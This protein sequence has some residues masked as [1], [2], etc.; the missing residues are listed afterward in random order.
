ML[1]YG[2]SG[3]GK[4]TRIACVLREL[5]G[6][7]V[8]KVRGALVIRPQGQEGLIVVFAWTNLRRPSA[9]VYV[10]R[11]CPLQLKIDQRVFMTPSRRNLD[12]NIVQSNYHLEITP[13]YASRLLILLFA[14][15]PCI[16]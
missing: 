11:P 15:Y 9:D 13:R 7:G 4:K 10:A 14:C 8:E 6:K 2:P 16:M 1:F 5:F 12:V 3:A